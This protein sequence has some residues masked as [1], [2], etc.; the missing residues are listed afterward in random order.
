MYIVLEYV[1]GYDLTEED[2]YLYC[3]IQDAMNMFKCML[4]AIKHMHQHNVAHMDI[5][6]ENILYNTAEK[7]YKL[8]DMGLSYYDGSP[9]AGDG[10]TL[11]YLSPEV[12]Q[13][14]SNRTLPIL[15]LQTNMKRDVWGLGIVLYC[16]C[17]QMQP[18]D[19]SEVIKYL[20]FSLNKKPA[21]YSKCILPGK[22]NLTK[23][24][25]IALIG[26]CCTDDVVNRPDIF[27]LEEFLNNLVI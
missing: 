6:P 10:G 14:I 8:I 24:I 3:D 2:Y 12:W 25:M 20:K 1:P 5:K 27:E 19:E 17:N 21:V 16:C 15:D 22:T 7:T 9:V 11:Q 13:A 26:K 4:S 23:E 18:Y